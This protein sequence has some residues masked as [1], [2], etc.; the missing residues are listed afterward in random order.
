MKIFERKIIRIVQKLKVNF[1]G[2]IELNR[3]YSFFQRTVFIIYL[4]YL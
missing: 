2:N 4:R 3:N 1:N